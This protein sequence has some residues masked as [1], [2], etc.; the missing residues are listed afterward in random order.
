MYAIARTVWRT[1]HFLVCPQSLFSALSHYSFALYLPSNYPKHGL[2][3][4]L[5]F[6][7]LG[8]YF[9]PFSA[10]KTPICL[11]SLNEVTILKFWNVMFF[12][13]GSLVLCIELCYQHLLHCE[14]FLS[15]YPVRMWA[16]ISHSSLC[17][18]PWNVRCPVNVRY[19]CCIK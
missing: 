9:L 4:L 16:E 14:L 11:Q 6:L 15:V 2:F 1:S 8:V 10:W 17:S 5:L 13:Y 12:F 18:H 19:S 3:P 7:L